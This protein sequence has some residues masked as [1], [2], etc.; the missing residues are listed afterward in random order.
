MPGGRLLLDLRGSSLNPEQMC[1]NCVACTLL[2][3][4]PYII[5]QA[6]QKQFT[7][8]RLPSKARSLCPLLQLS[9]RST[10]PLT[11]LYKSSI[12]SDDL[13]QSS[14]VNSSTSSTLEATGM[15]DFPQ[16]FGTRTEGGLSNTWTVFVRGFYC[17]RSQL[18]LHR[19]S[20]LV[21]V[22]ILCITTT[23]I[24][25]KTYASSRRGYHGHTCLMFPP[26][27]P[28]P[29]KRSLGLTKLSMKGC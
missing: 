13:R 27:S 3:H 29:I 16:R 15:T 14:L 10:N 8:F 17:T 26:W 5:C 19:S 12:A 2:R 1:R 22:L 6:F 20:I 9:N 4:G 28:L 23:C 11:R 25:S 18:S 21:I 24:Y 7:R